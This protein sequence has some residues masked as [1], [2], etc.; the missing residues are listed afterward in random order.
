M[1]KSALSPDFEP[2][3]YDGAIRLVPD[4]YLALGEDCF[5]D[6]D[7]A[8]HQ[9][10]FNRLRGDFAAASFPLFNELV[11][12]GLMRQCGTCDFADPIVLPALRALRRR[13]LGQWL[14]NLDT[15]LTGMDPEEA[16]TAKQEFRELVAVRNAL[17]HQPFWLEPENDPNAGTIPGR[18]K[19]RTVR[20]AAFIA[21]EHS[22]W[23][24]DDDQAKHWFAM[25]GRIL[26]IITA[27]RHEAQPDT[28]EGT[29]GGAENA[30]SVFCL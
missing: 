7:V 9:D 25:L 16:A 10:R 30:L 5:P 17:A 24:V 27:L 29:T 12:L 6:P 3:V 2:V 13:T 23:S 26:A 8:F 11:L 28:T 1:S 15:L 19:A 22:V 14:Q 21:D 20:Y 18:I 4:S